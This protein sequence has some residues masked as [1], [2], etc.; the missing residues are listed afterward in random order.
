MCQVQ[1]LVWLKLHRRRD[2]EYYSCIVFHKAFSQK[3]NYKILENKPIW[4]LP[5]THAMFL[6]Y[7]FLLFIWQ[8]TTKYAL[9][10]RTS[11]NL[12][13]CLLKPTRKYFFILWPSCHVRLICCHFDTFSVMRFDMKRQRWYTKIPLHNSRKRHIW[14]VFHVDN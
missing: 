12:Y 13:F 3:Q 5:P 7:I 4:H 11:A 9:F 6:Q 1:N 14:L 2:E 10:I 8:I